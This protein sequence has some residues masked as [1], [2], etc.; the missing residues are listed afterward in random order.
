MRYQITYTR[1]GE[2]PVTVM[3]PERGTPII[4]QSSYAFGSRGRASMCRSVNELSRMA[5][6]TLLGARLAGSVNASDHASAR[7]ADLID[8]L[9]CDL[10]FERTATDPGKSQ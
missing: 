10:G 6:R 7:T 3:F 2:Q 9:M 5:F 1:E 8:S 4:P